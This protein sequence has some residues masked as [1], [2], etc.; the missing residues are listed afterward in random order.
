M[1]V[2]IFLYKLFKF[3]LIQYSHLFILYKLWCFVP[4]YEPVLDLMS[5]NVAKTCSPYNAET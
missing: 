5:A 2:F 1:Y 3:I 4:T